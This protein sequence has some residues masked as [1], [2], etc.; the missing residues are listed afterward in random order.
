MSGLS[1]VVALPGFHLMYL[2]ASLFSCSLSPGCIYFPS[3]GLHVI[4]SVQGITSNSEDLGYG[5]SLPANFLSL[6]AASSPARRD[7]YLSVL[8]PPQ[9][10]RHLDRIVDLYGFSAVSPSLSVYSFR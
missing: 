3:A 9:T 4:L 10:G 2:V 5:V 7:G 6:S 8:S 1:P